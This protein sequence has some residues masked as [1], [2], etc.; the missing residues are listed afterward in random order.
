MVQQGSNTIWLD[1]AIETCS[2]LP[3][4]ILRALNTIAALDRKSQEL[5]EDLERAHQRCLDL[6]P[7]ANAEEHRPLRDDI[8]RMHGL[9]L[10]WA[11]ERLQLAIVAHE[12]VERHVRMVDEDLQGFEEDLI[13]R[14]AFQDVGDDMEP[15]E[16]MPSSTRRGAGG[17]GGALSGGVGGAL[18]GPTASEYTGGTSA[19][20]DGGGAGQMGPGQGNPP[21]ALRASRRGGGPPM[22]RMAMGMD[23]GHGGDGMGYGGDGVYAPVGVGQMGFINPPPPNL[24]D[25]ARRLQTRAKFLEY[26]DVNEALVGKHAEMYW[27]HDDHWYLIEIQAVDSGTRRATIMYLTGETEELE[28]DEIIRERHMVVIGL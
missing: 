1:N 12:Q 16:R 28:L 7:V 8:E 10:Q 22:Q 26:K 18:G 25:K 13:D 4:D 14:G 23:G 6:G 19:Q 9:L 3:P 24:K 17:L 5:R 11:E 2:T 21:P 15:Y 20:D 27:P